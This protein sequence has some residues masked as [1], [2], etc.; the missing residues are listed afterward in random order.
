MRATIGG[1]VLLVL[2]PAALIP[3]LSTGEIRGVVLS[4]RPDMLHTARI[5]LRN[6]ETRRFAQ[7]G[8]TGAFD[9][10]R[11]PPGIYE[12]EIS[13]DFFRTMPI[14]G[15]RVPSGEVRT[16]PPVA[17][18][19]DGI[20]DCNRRWPGYLSPLDRFDAG[21]GALAGRTI[22]NRGHPLAGAGVR[23]YISNVGV[24]GSAITDDT[25]RFSI[26]DVPARSRYEIEVAHDGFFTED[27]PDFEVQ[28]GFESFYDRIDLAPCEKD[29]CQPALRP[30]RKLHSCA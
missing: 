15:V 25:G 17:L 7:T 16:L 4:A 1:F 21:K 12:L 9:F 10:T 28:P 19:F 5:E 30:I 27:F 13:E 29:R 18:I 26:P 11:V 14:R 6:G 2:S 20:A 8:G 23:L 24:L 3:Q 22:D